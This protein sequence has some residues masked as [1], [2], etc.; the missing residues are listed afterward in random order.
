[1][2]L[3]TF[4]HIGRGRD[5]TVE[6]QG[7]FY[8][9]MKSCIWVLK[10]GK[11]SDANVACGLC[12]SNMGYILTTSCVVGKSCDSILGREINS[13]SFHELKIIKHGKSMFILEPVKKKKE[14]YDY[15]DI[16]D[17]SMQITA[18]QEVYCIAH[19]VSGLYSFAVGEVSHRKRVIDGTLHFQV[20]NVHSIGHSD[21]VFSSTGH[22]MGIVLRKLSHHSSSE[23]PDLGHNLVLHFS[24][25]NKFLKTFRPRASKSKKH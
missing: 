17:D 13:S 21:I 12:I 10:I 14:G 2:S 6:E 5:L 25:M 15:A 7:Q 20:A 3:K 16:S 8:S 4:T 11:G 9:L 24:E 19:E 23:E 18:C 22:V 1:M